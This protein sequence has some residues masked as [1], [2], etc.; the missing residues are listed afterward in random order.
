MSKNAQYATQ[1]NGEHEPDGGEATGHVIGETPTLGT[2]DEVGNE[3]QESGELP[4]EQATEDVNMD[5]PPPLPSSA[6]PPDSRP[7]S[8]L[9]D[10]GML[11]DASSPT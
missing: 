9:V 8:I 11:I 5:V 2:I 6:P 10:E 4:D 1:D 7:S 3:E